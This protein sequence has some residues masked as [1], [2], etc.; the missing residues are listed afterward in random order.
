L[1]GTAAQVVHAVQ[2]AVLLV[3]PE[4]QREL[5]LAGLKAR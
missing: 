5:K 1:G 2:T 3:N 4:H